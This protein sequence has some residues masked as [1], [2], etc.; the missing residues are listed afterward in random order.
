MVLDDQSWV[1]YMQFGPGG[2]AARYVLIN[3]VADS[4]GRKQWQVLFNENYFDFRRPEILRTIIDAVKAPVPTAPQIVV[5]PRSQTAAPGGTATLTVSANGTAPLSYQWQRAG[6]PIPGATSAS[7]VLSKVSLSD[8]GEYSVVVS[9]SAGSETSQ[10]ITL[11]VAEPVRPALGNLRRIDGGGVE[12]VLT[13][14]PGRNYHVEFS[15]DLRTWT[16]LAT[17]T[18]NDLKIIYRDANATGAAQGFYRAVG[19]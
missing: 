16:R 7:L 6:V 11:S 9:N 18:P 17:L 10:I 8:A 5:H 2:S 13:G 1:G 12:F 19:D 3:G 4:P 15:T 14:E